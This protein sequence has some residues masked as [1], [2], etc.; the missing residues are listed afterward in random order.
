[1]K[2][3]IQLLEHINVAG[4]IERTVDGMAP[5]GSLTLQEPFNTL[6]QLLAFDPDLGT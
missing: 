4:W 5:G 1:M 6:E 2:Q 3:I